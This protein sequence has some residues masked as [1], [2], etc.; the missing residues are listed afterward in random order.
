MFV[1]FSQFVVVPQH[2]VHQAVARAIPLLVT[3]WRPHQHQRWP[4]TISLI[5]VMH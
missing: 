2:D 4:K 5:V 3:K 1:V